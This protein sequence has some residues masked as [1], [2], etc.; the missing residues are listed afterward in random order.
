MPRSLVL[1]NGNIL[2]SLN[3]LGLVT[4]FYFPYVG[5]ENQM[6]RNYIHRVGVWCDG[7]FSWLT[8]GNWQISV[9]YQDETLAGITEAVNH[10]LQIR[11]LFED[12]VYNESNIFIRQVTIQNLGDYTRVVKVFFSQAFELYESYRGDT[13]YYDPATKTLIHYKGRR[14]LLVNAISSGRQFEEYSTGLFNIEGKEGTYKD[15][16]DGFL[17]KNP[18]EHGMVDSVLGMEF[19]LNASEVAQMHYWIAAAEFLQEAL[20]LNRYVLDKTPQHLMTTTSN[21]WKAWVGQQT[22]EFADLDTDSQI[23]FKQSLL[24]LRTHA[25][26]RGA[27]IASGDSS[28]LEHGRDTY[29]YMW[30]R[31]GAIIAS[32]FDLAGETSVSEQ[33][34][35]FCNEIISPEGYFMHKYR[36]D[37]SLGS[38]WHPWI[39]DGKMAYPIQE[40]ETALVIISLWHHYARAKD[41]EFIESVYNSLIKKAADFMVS[42]R[43]AKTKLPQSSFDLW[44]E[45]YGTHTFSVATV[46][47]ALMAAASFAA[48]LGKT[49]EKAKYESVATEIRQAILQYLYDEESGYFYKMITLSEDGQI[50][51]DKTIDISSIYGIF[52]YG[53]LSVDD[54]KVKRAMDVAIDK[55]M[56]QTPV[57]GIARFLGD[58]YYLR[59]E[60]VPGNPWFITT[61][62]VAQYYIAVAST[63]EEL[64]K[65]KEILEWVTHNALPSG[66][67]S[68]QLDPMTGEQLS[69][70]PLMWSHAEY[71]TTVVEYAL[72]YSSFK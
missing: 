28:M 71:I 35:K 9:S 58:V 14:V 70:A 26:N 46:Y 50:T 27:I 25:D 11:L 33:F 66:V 18:V 44:E 55:L 32:S 30:P 12:V 37:K 52:K 54:P 10:H 8:D 48:L 60:S 7:Q 34:F 4:D 2:I 45:K 23:L 57:K 39:R 31:D 29:S 6:G 56:T 3:K 24:I 68:E 22:F 65:A 36:A 47:A 16:E 61:L 53:I 1:G 43:D 5:L 15:A 49:D 40:D 62:W 51:T 72:K 67:L 21:Y 41:L 20:E 17:T 64:A 19:Q 38:S 42:Y 69:A 59:Y 13:A 63:N